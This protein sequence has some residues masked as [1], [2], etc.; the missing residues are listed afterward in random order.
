MST[1]KSRQDSNTSPAILK[2]CSAKTNTDSMV[3]STTTQN[4]VHNTPSPVLGGPER[5]VALKV[6]RSLGEST[7]RVNLLKILIKEKMG[8]AELEEF[9]LGV[10]GK[11]KS[12]KFKNKKSTDSNVKDKV[13]GQAMKRK[14]ADEQCLLREICEKKTRIRRILDKKLT[15]NSRPYRKIIQELNQEEA[16]TKKEMTEKYKNKVEHLKNKYGVNKT[17]DKSQEERAPLDLQE[18]ED[19]TIFNKKNFEEL[20]VD[21]YDVKVIG[22]IKLTV[23]EKKVLMLHPKFCVTDRLQ[24][25]N[26]ESEQESSFAKLRMEISKE[27]ENSE[28]T[29][30]QIAENEEFEA[31]TRRVYDDKNKI[32]DAR[33]RR[34]TDLTECSRVTLPKPLGIEEEAN[35][36]LRRKTQMEIFK[37]F[38]D[39]NT[40]KTGNQKSNLTREEHTGLKSLQKRIA[41]GEIIILKTDKSS[42]LAVT[43]PEEYKK[44]GLEHTAKDKIIGRQEVIEMEETLNGH[45]RAWA[46]IWNSGKDHKH[47]D[48]I[49]TSK[50]THSENVADLYLMYK[51]HKAGNKTRPTATG[52]TS[53]TLGLSNAVAEL[54]ESISNADPNRYNCIS[55]EDMLAR[56]HKSS[57]KILEIKLEMDQKLARKLQCPECKIMEMVDCFDSENHD[58]HTILKPVASQG[59]PEPWD[60]N[61]G[62]NQTISHDS[63]TFQEDPGPLET[64]LKID[65]PTIQNPAAWD[66]ALPSSISKLLNL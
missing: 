46:N 6:W 42:K 36:E 27:I 39:K 20:E 29:P 19:L 54:L 52:C 59:V 24:E 41:S 55:S 49:V 22:D 15:K 2:Q 40:D 18:Y 21:S 34:A 48:R 9:N 33:R 30:E 35:I 23:E 60:P 3:T 17:S 4:I 65:H 26:F 50:I 25:I 61:L 32:F 62:E 63:V 12:T 66:P 57:K 56:I 51:D 14:L 43:N 8:L 44:M 47:F 37:K 5:R 1:S 28:L 53:N 58:W 16:K 10:S 31:V 11:F 7:A 38:T 64:A 13:L 45:S